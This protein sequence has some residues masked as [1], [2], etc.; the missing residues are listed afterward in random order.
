MTPG[1]YVKSRQKL[2]ERFESLVEKTRKKGLKGLT[3]DELLELSRLYPAVAVD[4]SKIRMYELDP[5][6]EEKISALVIAAHG[7]LY[8][9]KRKRPMP[10][11]IDF[12]TQFYPRLF[13]RLG[14]YFMLVT[15]IFFVASLGAYV[16][17]QLDPSNAYLFVPCGLDISDSSTVTAEDV[18]ERFRQMPNAPMAAGIITNNISVALTAYALGVT[19]SLGTILVLMYNSLMLGG[20][21][22]HFANHG[23]SYELW[24]YIAPHGI[25][26]I[27]AILVSA[28]AGM[29]MGLSFFIPGHL[30]RF[31]S[32]R[33]GAKEAVLLVLGTIPMFILA[34]II[35]GFIT[36][37]YLP[38]PA[39]IIIGAA[40]FVSVFLYLLLGGRAPASTPI[41]N[42][43][44]TG[45]AP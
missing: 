13:R 41:P 15:A 4:V 30:T 9:E 2:W 11:L 42:P 21:I 8:R 17:T 45:T 33:K 18:S 10:D 29:R 12:F 32:L 7:M 26:E 36:P 44:T 1:G 20:F 25:L 40:A 16:S 3:R 19:A 39:K 28:A 24:C 23:L 22:G 5:R 43:P 35:E 38:G 14:G 31:A 27:F 34:G 37:S 6:L